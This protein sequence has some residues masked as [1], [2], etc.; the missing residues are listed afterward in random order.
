MFSNKNVSPVVT[1]MSSAFIL[2]SFALSNLVAETLNVLLSSGCKFAVA[3]NCF[4]DFTKVHRHFLTTL[5][6]ILQRCVP[7][8]TLF[9]PISVLQYTL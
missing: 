3:L 5:I 8:R 1:S 9:L 2:T 6:F 7:A 4:F